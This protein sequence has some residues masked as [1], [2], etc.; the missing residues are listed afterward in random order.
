MPV[1][2]D[3]LVITNIPLGL[4]KEEVLEVVRSIASEQQ[5]V[6]QQDFSILHF[7]P[8]HSR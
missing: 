4:S 8:S 2:G 1:V 3:K 5:W 7:V 6:E